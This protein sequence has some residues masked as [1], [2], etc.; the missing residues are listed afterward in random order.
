MFELSELEA[1]ALLVSH[2]CRRTYLADW[3]RELQLWL[4]ADETLAL[5]AYD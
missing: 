4:E 3:K 2:E 5:A 1:A